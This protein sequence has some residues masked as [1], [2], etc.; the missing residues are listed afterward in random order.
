ME[1]D[2]EDR[3]LVTQSGNNA[4]VPFVAVWMVTYNHDYFIAQAIESVMM[5]QTSFPFKLIIGEDCSTDN[6][7]EICVQMQ[8]KFGSKIELS[9]NE[10]NLGASIN[11]Y[12][13]FEACFKSGAKYIALLE[14]DDYWT[15]PYKL[16]KQVDFL[17]QTPS[18]SI[19]FCHTKIVNSKGE[20]ILKTALEPPMIILSLRDFLKG[21]AAGNNTCTSIFKKD[22]LE[23]LDWILNAPAGDHFLWLKLIKKGKAAV[24]PFY[25]G[26]YRV[27]TQGLWG[28]LSENAVLKKKIE[29]LEMLKKEYFDEPQSRGVIELQLAGLM[30]QKQSMENSVK[31]IDIVCFFLKFKFS[32]LEIWKGKHVFKQAIKSWIKSSLNI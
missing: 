30:L 17:E 32:L 11:A 8:K 1:T 6:T 4:G 23:N 12:K 5:Q 25:G 2:L 20:I 13:T 15:D 26:A 28:R 16:Q 31:L 24:L 14:G 19:C 9:L 7:R 18:Y 21:N 10:K 27:H 29:I 22:D 3:D